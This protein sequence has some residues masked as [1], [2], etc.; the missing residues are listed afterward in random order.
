M[1]SDLNRAFLA[2]V[3]AIH[4]DKCVWRATD[5]DGKEVS[6][7][8]GGK[9]VPRATRA[10]GTVALGAKVSFEIDTDAELDHRV[11]K[12]WTTYFAS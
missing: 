9:R 1:A 7:S 11:S 4:L 10:E 2:K 6:I 5:P 3:L 8:V 12:A